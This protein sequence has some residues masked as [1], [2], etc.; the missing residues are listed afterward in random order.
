MKVYIVIGANDELNNVSVC[1][2]YERRE[3]AEKHLKEGD[4]FCNR[5]GPIVEQIVEREYIPSREMLFGETRDD[6]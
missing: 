2:V 6:K 3:D 4:W 5:M 1:G